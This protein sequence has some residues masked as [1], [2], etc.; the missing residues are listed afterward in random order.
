MVGNIS[1]TRGVLGATG[2]Q[3]KQGIQG[4]KGDKGDIGEPFTY[5]MF[6]P[7][8]LSALKGEK[9]DQ[10]EQGIQGRRGEA[11]T[12]DDFTAEQ[13]ASLKGEKGDQGEQGIQGHKGDKG[14]KGDKGEKG[15][16][17]I[18][19]EKGDRGNMPS[20]YLRLDE[21]TGN[22]YYNSDGIVTSEEYVDTGSFA[23]KTSIGS[24][25]TL[26]TTNKSNLVAAI[27]ELY[28]LLR[29]SH[30]YVVILGGAENWTAEDVVDD[31]GNVVG[32]K[33]GQ[34]V[35]VNNAIITDR[36]KVD[37]QF[38]MDQFA[39]F[40]AKNISFSTTN[41]GGVVTVYCE[42]E[43]PDYNYKIQATVTEVAI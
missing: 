38:S 4:P 2:P 37:L 42:G 41:R 30:A 34:V 27:N 10:G 23:D 15:D 33:Y 19:G 6:T 18:Q 28:D 16:Q 39:I 40:K 24:M 17:G 20:V 43:I 14:D 13:L 31:S 9:G 25:D 5:D 7:E 32:V 22:L 1:K 35:N 11:F 12:Y 29:P 36:S 21:A 26:K 3:G 8:Q